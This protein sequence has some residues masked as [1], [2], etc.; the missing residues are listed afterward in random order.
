MTIDYERI[1][2]E[3]NKYHQEQ[4]PPYWE[5]DI[6]PF[7]KELAEKMNVVPSHLLI[8][9]GYQGLSGD[10]RELIRNILLLYRYIELRSSEEE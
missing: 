9:L 7:V 5:M 4:L 6:H 2:Q 3:M 10:P 1:E 8:A